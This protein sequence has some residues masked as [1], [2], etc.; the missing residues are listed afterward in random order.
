MDKHFHI[1]LSENR[2]QLLAFPV[3]LDGFDIFEVHA[4][5]PFPESFNRLEGIFVTANKMTGIDEEKIEHL[6]EG[7]PAVTT[8]KAESLSQYITGQI[9]KIISNRIR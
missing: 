1:P 3:F 8:A 2:I 4:E 6:S 9:E 7:I 5:N